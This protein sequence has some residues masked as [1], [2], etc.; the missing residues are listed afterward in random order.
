MHEQRVPPVKPCQKFYLLGLTARA[1]VTGVGP[2]RLQRK[3]G[4]HPVKRRVV[5]VVLE[6]E[7]RERSGDDLGDRC[8]RALLEHNLCGRAGDKHQAARLDKAHAVVFVLDCRLMGIVL[9]VP[10]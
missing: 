10:R 8:V 2:V 6:P 4:L 3:T 9:E 7:A 5:R 1:D